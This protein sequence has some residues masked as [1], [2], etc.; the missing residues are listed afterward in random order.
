MGYLSDTF[1][2]DK[3]WTKDLWKN[4]KSDPKRLILG[5]D[6]ASTWAWNKVLGRDDKPLVDQMGGPYDGR[7]LSYGHD[8]GEVFDRAKAAGINTDAGRANH[9]AAHVVAA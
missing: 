3:F 8:G 4:I 1:A 6:P 2:F 7:V 5:V 9:D